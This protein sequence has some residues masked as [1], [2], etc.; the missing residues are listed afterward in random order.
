MIRLYFPD[1]A[2][3]AIRGM[4]LRQR[5]H[6]RL[7]WTDQH[8]AS[9][10]G[11]GVLERGKSGAILS[12]REFAT[13]HTTFGAW[14]QYTEPKERKRIEHALAW[15]ATGLPESALRQAMPTS[16]HPQEA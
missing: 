13:L 4:G 6:E 1:Q 15:P 5:S 11:L 2:I 16:A 8:P 10:Y 9:S 3:V 7:R 12:G 14:I